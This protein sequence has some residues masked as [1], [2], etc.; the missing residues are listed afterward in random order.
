MTRIVY[1]LSL[2]L[3]YSVSATAAAPQQAPALAGTV[4]D[5]A[6]GIE[7]VLVKGGCYQMG[8]SY[9]DDENGERPPHEVCLSDFYLGKFEVTQ[10]QWQAIMGSNP[11]QFKQCGPNCPVEK[12]SWRDVQEFLKRLGKRSG[13]SYRLPTEAE[14]EYAARSGGKVQQYAGGDS[15]AEFA[16]FAG[17]SGAN[18]HP[19][20]QKQPNAIGLFDMTGNVWEWV[21][22]WY[23][24]T[25]YLEGPKKNPQ[26][27]KTGKMRVLRGGC[28]LND[29]T[30]LRTDFRTL[31]DP[32]ARFNMVGF[33]VALPVR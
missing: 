5:P 12:V 13:K 21:Q 16:W 6:S 17:N 4:K 8:G 9:G 15:P 27:P 19:A 14:W 25:Y 7:L 20:G 23:G 10:K 3:F 2:A 11:A 1:L 24:L 29:R 22:D 33:R 32:G 28:A 18:V 31:A 30:W 26:G